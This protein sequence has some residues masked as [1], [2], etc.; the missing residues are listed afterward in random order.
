VLLFPLHNMHCHFCHCHISNTYASHSS[1]TYFTP[2][3]RPT[4]ERV[5]F[6]SATKKCGASRG[7]K[8]PN[9]PGLPIA[10]HCILHLF[11]PKPSTFS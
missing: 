2:P 7:R 9:F 6:A 3:R 10:S 8:V 11:Q 4:L 1:L 5:A